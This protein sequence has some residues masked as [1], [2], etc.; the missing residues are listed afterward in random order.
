M[1]HLAKILTAVWLVIAALL[2]SC[3]TSPGGFD[4]TSNADCLE[5]H[6]CIGGAC[7]AAD[8]LARNDC[9]Y[10]SYCD[11]QN[12]QCAEGCRVDED[13][14]S[15]ERCENRQCVDGGCTDTQVDCAFGE[16]CDLESGVCYDGGDLYCQECDADLECGGSEN[17]CLQQD[18]GSF[19]GV[20]CYTVDDC[21]QGYDCVEVQDQYGNPRGSNCY[22]EC[23]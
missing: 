18:A 9:P 20:A 17:Y 19:C 6:A 10:G 2:M 21:P 11:I 22:A 1:T 13:C 8:C 12:Y 4:C 15:G 7:E 23:E 5:G 3:E 16:F 14:H